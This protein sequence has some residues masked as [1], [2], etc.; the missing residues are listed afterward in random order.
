MPRRKSRMLTEVELEFM[1]ILWDRGEVTTE[2]VQDVIA[3]Q[4]R[5]E[6]AGGSVRKVLAILAG[7]GYVTRRKE[8]RGYV[9]RA[10][11]PADTANRSMVRDL[12]SRAFG[13]SA[14]LMVTALLES[15][16]VSDAELAQIK[17]R[18]EEHEEEPR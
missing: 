15:K 14:A 1:Q 6:L 8:G 4:R 18:I 10:A 5:Q 9:Y 17:R 7:K 11:V 16:R 3:R 13:G 2:D 12:L